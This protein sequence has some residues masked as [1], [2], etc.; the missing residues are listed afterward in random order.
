MI[1]SQSLNPILYLRQFIGN[2]TK[3][4]K[5][6]GIP[7]RT[8]NSGS[9]IHSGTERSKLKGRELFKIIN[10]YHKNWE[11]WATMLKSETQAGAKEYQVKTPELLVF[12]GL[13][14]NNIKFWKKEM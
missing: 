8:N 5:K 10:L 14:T 6:E 13:L 9:T 3:R 2:R 1:C 11:P 4:E 12:P 7:H